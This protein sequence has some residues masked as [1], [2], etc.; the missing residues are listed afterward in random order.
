MPKRPTGVR[1]RPDGTWEARLEVG[2]Q[3]GRRVQKSYYG[4][5]MEEAVEKRDRARALA[6]DGM[7]PPSSRLTVGE[8]LDRWLRHKAPNLRRKS[9]QGYELNIR[10]HLKPHLGA[11]RLEKLTPLHVQALYDELLAQGLSR[12]SVEYVHAVLH[13]ALAHAVRL[14]LLVHNPADRVVVPRPGRREMRALGPEEAQRLVDALAGDRLQPLFLLALLTGMRQEEILGLKWEDVD[15]EGGVL[16]VRRTLQ[17]ARGG[18]IVWGEPKSETSRRTLPLPPSLV[19]ALRHHRTRQEWERRRA[20]PAWQ[21]HGVVFTREDGRPLRPEFVYRYLQRTLAAAGLPR[22]RFH[23]LRHTFATLAA[24]E[25]GA[26]SK[27]IAHLLGHSTTRL[28]DDLYRHVLPPV[29]RETV[30][31][32]DRALLGRDRTGRRR[33]GSP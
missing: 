26:D 31:R 10:L 4:R 9:L 23:D 16:A 2:R 11:V 3:G 27:R 28:T 20:G 8:W 13:G 25:A 1:Q 32:L 22:V 5:T 6:L 33:T 21:E 12:R 29:A 30:E 24:S 14:G 18:R 15:L 17:W 19:Q 7:L